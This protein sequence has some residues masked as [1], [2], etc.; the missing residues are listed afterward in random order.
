LTREEY[1]NSI[2]S[3]TIEYNTNTTDNSPVDKKGNSNAITPAEIPIVTTYKYKEKKS[4]KYYGDRIKVSAWVKA[5]SKSALISHSVQYSVTISAS[6]SVTAGSQQSAIKHGASFTITSAKTNANTYGLYVS[7]HRTGAIYFKPY[8]RKTSGTLTQYN[9]YVG[10]V[11]SK[12]V[13]ARSAIK[14]KSGE[15]DGIYYIVYK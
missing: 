1:Y 13:Y 11:N 5:G 2:N 10:K 7:A 6:Y 9:N 3:S 4:T 12:S 8:K 15:A 14:L